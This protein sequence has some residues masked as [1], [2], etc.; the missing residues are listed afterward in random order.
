MSY[1]SKIKCTIK[2]EDCEEAWKL[3]R[4][5]FCAFSKFENGRCYCIKHLPCRCPFIWLND[6]IWR[7]IDG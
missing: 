3:N 5:G 4:F 2:Q 6:S 1:P 7:Y